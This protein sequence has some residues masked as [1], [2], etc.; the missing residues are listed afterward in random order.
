M[1]TT[2]VKLHDR[3][4]TTWTANMN[5]TGCTVRLLAQKGGVTTLLASVI[6]NAPLGVVTHTLDGTL[7][8]GT[9]KVE[10]EVS[11]V[12]DNLLATF[13][14]KGTETLVVEKDLG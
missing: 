2:T 11:R 9:Y 3:H 7:E 14:N 5:L 4:P 10:L 8:V 6:T 1:T 12:G 13:P